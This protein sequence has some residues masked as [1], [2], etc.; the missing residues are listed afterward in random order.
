MNTR[1]IKYLAVLITLAIACNSVTLFPKPT[2]SPQ[3][4]ATTQPKFL[5]FEN[6]WVAFDYP[7]GMRIFTAGDPAFITYPHDI[8]L[9][10]ELVA[11]L[12]HPNW[13]KFDTLFSSIGI[14]RHAKPPG[15]NLETIMQTAY[16][17]VSLQNEI[18]EGSDPVTIDGLTAHQRTYRVASG[19]LW[20]TL[21]D[22]WVEKDGG[23]MRLSI[24]EEVYAIDFQSP[25]DIFISSLNIKDKLPHF[26]EKPTPEPT[27]SPSPYPDSMLL[28]F[29]NDVVA[30]HYLKGMKLYTAGDP[31]FVCYP[32]IQLGGELVVGMGDPKFI[33]LNTYFRS[34]RIFRLPMPPGSNLEA[35][36]LE[37][38]RQAEKK[39]S[40]QKVVLNA[41]GPVTIDGLAAIQKTYR[42]YSGEPAYELRDIWVQN[43]NELFILSIWTE[44]TNPD[45]YAAF[46]A[47]ADMFIK[48]L[49]IKR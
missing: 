35:I 23:I 42:V 18:V 8:Q 41:N 1:S 19:P 30:F 20:Y 31:A 15:S 14:F 25:A 45:D 36:F 2:P 9:G 17:H 4:T 44:Y 49:E 40:L 48:S 37:A 27:P 33:N 6:E 39:F 46:Q 22:I 3:P 38:Y 12:A 24:W 13:I 26:E 16:E 5:H 47:I 34:I 32:D 43:G 11:G 29:E 28:H 10:G 21:R 7:E